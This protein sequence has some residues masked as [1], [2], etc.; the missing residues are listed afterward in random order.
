MLSGVMPKS[1]QY[2]H[3]GICALVCLVFGGLAVFH[4]QL[5]FPPNGDR[6]TAS[7]T[8]LS[9]GFIT[10]A[11]GAIIMQLWFRRR[12]VREFTYSGSALHIR[13]LG[14]HGMQ[15]YSLSQLADIRDWRG[16]R[17]PL[18]YRLVFQD[19]WNAY[20]ELR[21]E[22]AEALAERLVAERFSSEGFRLGPPVGSGFRPDRE[23]PPARDER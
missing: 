13:T 4:I 9:V 3:A 21:V 16:R 1:R 23:P 5:I 6:T 12:I 19:G 20:I 2:F 10:L 11:L 17:G 18:G 8:G 22:N 15:T 14:I 7:A